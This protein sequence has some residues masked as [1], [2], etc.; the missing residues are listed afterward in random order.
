LHKLRLSGW[1]NRQ[2]SQEPTNPLLEVIPNQAHLFQLLP[3]WIRYL[4]IDISLSR[5][6]GTGVTATH[7]HYHVGGPDDLVTPRLGNLLADVDP[8]F[9]HCGNGRPIE[10][11]SG[12]RTTRE[13]VELSSAQLSRPASGHLGTSGVMHAQKEHA[14]IHNTAN[15]M[16]GVSSNDHDCMQNT[17]RP[18]P[19]RSECRFGRATTPGA[20]G[21]RWALIGVGFVFAQDGPD[22]DPVGRGFFVEDHPTAPAHRAR[23]REALQ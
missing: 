3:G 7:R 4:P 20:L 13:D 17:K 5:K 2:L 19:P 21:S 6:H 16:H 8:L 10:F 22:R 9:R 23:L 18:D 15:L 11:A 12:F 14:R 1:L